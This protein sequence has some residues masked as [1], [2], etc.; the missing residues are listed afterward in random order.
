M[1]VVAV[2]F[3]VFSI[4]GSPAAVGLVGLAEVVPLIIFAVLGGPLIDTADRRR[5]MLVTQGLL[6]L[7]SIVLAALTLAGRPS[8]WQIYV[9]V[10]LASALTAIDQPARN[11]MTPRLVRAEQIPAAMALRQVVFQTTQIAGPALGGLLIAALSG[12]GWLYV[13]DA[14]TF[15]AALV[16][17]RWVPPATTRPSSSDEP[18]ATPGAIRQGLAFAFR[19]PVI[20]SIFAIDLVAMIFGMPR[21]VFPAL[22]DQTFNVNPTGLGLLYAAPSAGAL[23]GALSSGW[24]RRVQRR[25]V[26]VLAAVA[27]WGTAITLAGLALFSFPLT[28]FCLA[29]AGAADV[30][31]AVFRGSMM[32]DETPDELLGRV[33]GLNLMVVAGGPRLGDV[34]AGL[35]AE[36]IGPGSSVVV[37]GLACLAGTLVVGASSASL[38]RYRAPAVDD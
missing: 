30:F 37:G 23:L 2:A 8:L 4:T 32:L 26:A 10:A 34:E 21:A 1:R 22:A 33:N 14:L 31:S 3:Q 25:G 19:N 6:V 7:D 12:V 27:A 17:L 15:F 13:I 9:L 24:V 20:L 5:I 16:A 11:A 18:R 36:L 35:V 28:L 29:V 38:R